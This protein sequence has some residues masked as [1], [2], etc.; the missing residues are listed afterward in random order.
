MIVTDDDDTQTSRIHIKRGEKRR[1][2][3]AVYCREPTALALSINNKQR[4]FSSKSWIF[5]DTDSMRWTRYCDYNRLT[6]KPKLYRRTK[7]EMNSFPTF[8][9]ARILRT[10]ISIL[11]PQICHQTILPHFFDSRYS[12]WCFIKYLFPTMDRGNMTFSVNRTESRHLEM[13]RCTRAADP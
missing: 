6:R 10:T 4:G 11:T 2:V 7:L 12:K 9:P 5:D 3:F 1:N 8:S 13:Y